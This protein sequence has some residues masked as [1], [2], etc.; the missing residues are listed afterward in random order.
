M[1]QLCIRLRDQD[2]QKLDELEARLGKN[3]TEVIRDLI[4]AG[5]EREA[6]NKILSEI[7]VVLAN[8]A[9]QKMPVDIAEIKRIVTLIGRAMPAISKYIP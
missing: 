9:G 8:I 6:Q 7:R 1:P 5:Y 2:K 3:T 4:Q